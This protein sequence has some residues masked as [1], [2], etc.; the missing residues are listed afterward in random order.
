[1]QRYERKLRYAMVTYCSVEVKRHTK[2][3]ADRAALITLMF[4]IIQSTGAHAALMALACYHFLMVS[5]CKELKVF[6]K[7]IKLTCPLSVPHGGKTPKY[8]PPLFRC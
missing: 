3:A 6:R 2:Q 1:V 4:C 7:P 5:Y 8:R